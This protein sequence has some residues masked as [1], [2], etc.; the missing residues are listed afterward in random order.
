MSFPLF[1]HVQWQHSVGGIC[2]WSIQ[3]CG[4]SEGTQ[5]NWAFTQYI[6]K[7]A[8]A[9]T[10][11][12]VEV[13]VNVTHRI[14]NCRERNRCNPEFEV[15]KYVTSGPQSTSNVRNRDN[16]ERVLHRRVEVAAT[17][18]DQMCFTLRDQDKGFYVGLRD[19]NSCVLVSRVIAYRHECDARQVGLVSFPATASPTEGSRSL[20]A[21]C[22][23]NAE[24]VSSMRVQCRSD[25]IWVGTPQCRCKAGYKQETDGEGNLR[26]VGEYLSPQHI[27]KCTLLGFAT[28]YHPPTVCSCTCMY[29]Y[30]NPRPR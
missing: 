25:G 6:S 28:M 27:H 5:E 8:P 14:S 16:Y 17:L 29:M 21:Q 13:C 3:S 30:I 7:D 1:I 26:C 2:K 24:P 12:D 10:N 22:V 15:Y 19:P 11:Y 4:S 23:A 18:T 9:G 20:S